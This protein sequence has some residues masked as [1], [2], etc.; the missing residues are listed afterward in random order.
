MQLLFVC[1]LHL[2]PASNQRF[3]PYHC[4]GDVGPN[5]CDSSPNQI[6]FSEQTKQQKSNLIILDINQTILESINGFHKSIPQKYRFNK[7]PGQFNDFWMPIPFEQTTDIINLRRNATRCSFNAYKTYESDLL[8]IE[9]PIEHSI[10]FR[11]HFFHFLKYI[12][13]NYAFSAD[14]ILYTQ[15]GPKYAL[16]IA[17]G[18]TEFYRSKY[19]NLVEDNIMFKMVISSTA[20]ETFKTISTLAHD[21]DLSLYENIMILDKDGR[22]CWCKQG[23]INLRVKHSVNIVL[24]QVPEFLYW[25]NI[26]DAFKLLEMGRNKVKVPDI[27]PQLSQ[28]FYSLIAGNP[29]QDKFFVRFVEFL[30][31]LYYNNTNV[32][33]QFAVPRRDVSRFH[34]IVALDWW[35]W[36]YK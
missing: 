17:L 2:M 31:L 25:S 7:K 15:S 14:L 13:T 4:H 3:N 32:L 20:P 22:D 5:R 30:E 1:L 34:R 11:K 9:K 18:I 10:I 35:E 6:V 12:D 29:S 16:L 33:Y 8:F 28:F 27:Q 23:M 21:L 26:Y 19:Y 24:I 36:L